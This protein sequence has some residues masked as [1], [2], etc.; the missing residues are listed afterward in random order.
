MHTSDRRKVP[1][2]GQ[3]KRHKYLCTLTDAAGFCSSHTCLTLINPC[4]ITL[5]I[6]KTASIFLPV[7][8]AAV[9]LSRP[10][11]ERQNDTPDC[12]DGTTDVNRG[13]YS[14]TATFYR[15]QHCHRG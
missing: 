12:V 5:P 10:L 15:T 6:M 7:A 1:V 13:P 2:E 8:L 11:E 3:N 9:A 14:G 4:S